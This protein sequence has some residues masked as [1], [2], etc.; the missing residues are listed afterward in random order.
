MVRFSSGRAYQNWLLFPAL[1]VN[2]SDSE[3]CQTHGPTVVTILNTGKDRACAR[4]TCVPPKCSASSP[5][6]FRQLSHVRMLR[7]TTVRAQH[8]VLH[9]LFI[10]S[11]NSSI[12]LLNTLLRRCC[13]L[14]SSDVSIVRCPS[15]PHLYHAQCPDSIAYT[16]IRVR[17]AMLH[18][19][20]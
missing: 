13:I 4:L 3:G 9:E 6:P 11:F 19:H 18:I 20:T 1:V 15:C 14:A 5:Q 10:M 2:T 7:I 8:A 12:P 17:Y 16:Y